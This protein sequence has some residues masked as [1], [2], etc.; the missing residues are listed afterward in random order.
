MEVSLGEHNK[1]TQYA[2]LN[3]QFSLTCQI[4]FFSNF[5]FFKVFYWLYWDENVHNAQTFFKNP[6]LPTHVC[7]DPSGYKSLTTF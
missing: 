5:I 1:F 3:T 4:H 2:T 7:G 6:E